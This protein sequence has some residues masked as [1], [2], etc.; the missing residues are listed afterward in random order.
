MIKVAGEWV[1]SLELEDAISQ[2]PSVSE[3]AVVGEMDT[4][5]GERPVALVVL[6]EGKELSERDLVKH[7]RG[8]TDHGL[9]NELVVHTKLKFVSAIDKTSVGKINKVELRKKYI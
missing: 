6:R 2:H 3:V 1:S 7:L 9:L 5:L 8:F 4:K